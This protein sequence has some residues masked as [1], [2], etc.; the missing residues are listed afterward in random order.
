[1]QIALILL[2]AALAFGVSLWH[3]YVYDDYAI[4]SDPLLFA[5]AGWCQIWIER[6]RPLT[7]LTFRAEF[8]HASLQHGLNLA[9]HMTA[10]WLAFDSLSRLLPRRAAVI[11]TLLFAVHPLQGETV[12]YVWARSTLLMAVLCLL[13]LRDWTREH[14]WRAVAWFGL[15]LL[16][17]E[18]A[19]VFPL[20]LLLLRRDWK[21][22]A[23]MM[24]LSVAAG[25]RVLWAASTTPGSQAGAQ[26]AYSVAEYFW[27]QG[28]VALRYLFSIVWPTA[29]TPDPPIAP[30]VYWWAWLLIGVAAALSYRRSVWFIAGVVLLLPS[31]SVFPASELSA[32]RRMYL[33]MLAFAASTGLLL[34]RWKAAPVALAAILI[35][36]SIARA[37]VWE[38]DRTLWTDA[39]RKN[40]YS[41]RARLRLGTVPL[42]EEAKK[43]DPENPRVATELGRAYVQSGHPEQ[44]L[45]E[46]G[47]ALALAPNSPEALSN[48]GVALLLLRQSDAARQDFERALKVEPCFWDARYNLKRMGVSKPPPASCLYTPWQ[49]QMLD[50]VR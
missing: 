49:Q 50:Q 5:P 10:V 8:H 7:Y 39:L 15:A 25:A 47:R 20:V 12:N 9:L 36:L 24:A 6:T 22:F 32:D 16:A 44:A 41:V 11:A 18:E 45:S 40:E 2:A 26:A 48:R 30:G 28:L 42:L 46:F 19:V 21:P 13:S 33:P 35:P 3:G 29:L 34:R 43:L 37:R 14:R 1:M 4:F 27:T 17:K 38:S 23:A 31:S